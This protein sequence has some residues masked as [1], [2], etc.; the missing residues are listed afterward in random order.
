MKK[1]KT[2]SK[3]CR[4]K[5]GDC[6]ADYSILVAQLWMGIMVYTITRACV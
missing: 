3:Y 5:G 6:N 1:Y 4:E 2:S